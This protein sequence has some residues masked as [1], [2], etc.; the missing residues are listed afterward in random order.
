MDDTAVISWTSHHGYSYE[1]FVR[2]YSDL[3]EASFDLSVG[4]SPEGEYDRRHENVS[5]NI[6]PEAAAEVIMALT[7]AFGFDPQISALL[8]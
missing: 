6:T 3:G 4:C 7:E 5:S 2:E 8:P 1:L